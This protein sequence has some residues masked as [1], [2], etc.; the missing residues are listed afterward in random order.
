M[1]DHTAGIEDES[2]AFNWK[3]HSQYFS[4]I[5]FWDEKCNGGEDARRFPEVRTQIDR[6]VVEWKIW[7]LRASLAG[8]PISNSIR[9]S[10]SGLPFKEP[11]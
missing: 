5:H 6:R 10:L 8:G 1:T 7:Q 4:D 3:K 2:A 11:S 9:D